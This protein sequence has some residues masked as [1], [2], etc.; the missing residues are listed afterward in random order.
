MMFKH[1]SLAFVTFV[2]TN[3]DDL[4]ILSMYFASPKYKTSNIVLGQYLGIITLTVVSL[5]GVLLGGFVDQR[6]VSLLGLVPIFL[7]IKDLI[8]LRKTDEVDD[9]VQESKSKFQ[10][11]NVALVTIANG[12]DN[13]GVYTPLFATTEIQYVAMY[14]LVFMIL[15]AAWCFLGYWTVSHPRVK[16]VFAKYGKIILPFFLIILGIFILRDFFNH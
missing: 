7:G 13:I 4:L 14:A 3:L 2:V 8:A 15:T 12:G 6:W 16:N 1:I 9:E 11:L 5:V 10:F